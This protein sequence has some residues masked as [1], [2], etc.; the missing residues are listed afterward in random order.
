MHI[1]QHLAAVCGVLRF[2]GRPL[3]EGNFAV[4]VVL[5]FTMYTAMGQASGALSRSLSYVNLDVRGDVFVD[6]DS[7]S[8]G[9]AVINI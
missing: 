9:P 8:D 3:F 7:L 4:A 6:D 2:S 5:T 1:L